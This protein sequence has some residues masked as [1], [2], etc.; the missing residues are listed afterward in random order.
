[1]GVVEIPSMIQCKDAHCGR[2][3]MVKYTNQRGY[4]REG[5]M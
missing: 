4:S 3:Y 1:M 5:L 2:S